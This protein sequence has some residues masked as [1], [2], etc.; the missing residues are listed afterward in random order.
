MCGLR[1]TLNM[2][3]VRSKPI[4]SEWGGEKCVRA[5]GVCGSWLGIYSPTGAVVDKP[6]DVCHGYV[7]IC[8]SAPRADILLQAS[9]LP[10][11]KARK[12]C[13]MRMSTFGNTGR[14]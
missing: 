5:T 7:D 8:G 13:V 3:P 10:L 9:P 2:P 12:W 14:W 6:V 11:S 1:T 4:F